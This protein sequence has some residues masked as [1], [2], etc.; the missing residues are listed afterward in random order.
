[1]LTRAAEKY[2]VAPQMGNQ[3]ASGDD[4][5]LVCESIRNGDIGEIKEVHAWTNRPIW[6]QAL[7][8]P[9]ETPRKPSGLNWNL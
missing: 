9:E 1:M 7:N 5:A 2:N 8:R 3:G 6:P 4:T